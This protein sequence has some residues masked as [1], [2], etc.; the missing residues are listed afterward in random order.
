[1]EGINPERLES[2]HEEE[3]LRSLNKIGGRNPAKRNCKKKRPTREY[4]E[5]WKRRKNESFN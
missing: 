1:M 5:R 3:I 2:D 4:K